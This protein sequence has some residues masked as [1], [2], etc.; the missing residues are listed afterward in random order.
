MTTVCSSP[1]LRAGRPRFMSRLAALTDVSGFNH[2]VP[3]D[4]YLATVSLHALP[5]SLFYSTQSKLLKA[6]LNQ[7]KQT[8]QTSMG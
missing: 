5:K 4:K 6:S 2:S 3:R 8:K 1:A 7:S